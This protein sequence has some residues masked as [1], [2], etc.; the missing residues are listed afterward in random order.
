MSDVDGVE[1]SVEWVSSEPSSEDRV[2]DETL[3]S[4]VGRGGTG[5]REPG[6]GGGGMDGGGVSGGSLAGGRCPFLRRGRIS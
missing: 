6:T 2:A 4:M 3:L 5:G 1:R